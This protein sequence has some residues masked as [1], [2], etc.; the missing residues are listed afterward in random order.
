[1]DAFSEILSGV[2]LNGAVFFN[3]EFSDPWRFAS[4]ASQTLACTLAPG[5][6]HVVIYHLLT[7][8]KALLRPLAHGD[9]NGEVEFHNRSGWMRS[10]RS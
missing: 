5:A 4:P 2:K 6:P 10:S 7:E 9:C 1:V 8:G 3:A